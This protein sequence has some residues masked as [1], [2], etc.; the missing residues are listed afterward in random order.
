LPLAKR[1]SPQL[2]VSCYNPE[3]FSD[4]IDRIFQEAAMPFSGVTL[5]I[6]VLI[7]LFTTAEFALSQAKQIRDTA[8]KMRADDEVQILYTGSL[9]GYF[10]M[11]DWQHPVKGQKCPIDAI[12][13][14]A[15]EDFDTVVKGL[16][17]DPQKKLSGPILLSSG[18]SFS[19][20]IEAREFCTAP[21]NQPSGQKRVGKDSF[22]WN[23]ESQQWVAFEDYRKQ[24]QSFRDRVEAGM[25]TIPPDNVSSFLTAQ[26]YAAVVPGRHDFYFGPERLRLLARRLASDPIPDNVTMAHLP[27]Y[28]TQML[29]ANLVIE[30][31]WKS[32]HT[33]LS[34]KEDPP[35][36]IPRLPKAEELELPKT[37][38]FE[39]IDVPAGGN[40]YPWYVGSKLRLSVNKASPSKDSANAEE[41][42]EAQD[43]DE[44]KLK[45][46]S[47]DLR[48]AVEKIRALAVNLCEA[49]PGFDQKTRTQE[50]SNCRKIELKCKKAANKEEVTLAVQLPW[51][52]EAHTYTLK[53]GIQYRLCFTAKKAIVTDRDGGHTFCQRLSVYRP[54]FQFPW[55][56][57]SEVCVGSRSCPYTDPDPYLELERE[58][59]PG[60]FTDV[61][62][63]G[64]VN[65]NLVK[66]IGLLNYGWINREKNEKDTGFKTV[67]AAKDPAEA[68]KELMAHYERRW[69]E[70]DK[71]PKNA[72]TVKIR[73]LMAEMSPQEAE[74]LATRVRNFQVVLTEADEA[75]SKPFEND[76]KL[77]KVEADDGG[78]ARMPAVVLVPSP[79]FRPGAAK[80]ITDV[81]FLGL[82]PLD[83]EPEPQEW[84]LTSFHK[85]KNSCLYKSDAA[86]DEAATADATNEEKPFWSWL[87]RATGDHCVSGELSS[88][89]LKKLETKTL[90]E[91]RK[92]AKADVV[93]LQKRDFFSRLPKDFCKLRGEQRSTQEI[94]DRIIWKGD[95]LSRIFVPGSAIKKALEQSKAFDNEDSSALS[96]SDE[97]AL[98]LV[99]LG[100]VEDSEGSGYLI[101]GMPL[102]PNKLYAVATT[103]YI[104]AGDTGYPDLASGQLEQPIV[105]TDFGSNLTSISSVVCRSITKASDCEKDFPARDYFDV[106]RVEPNDPR[107]G[108]T[109]GKQLEIWSIFHRPSKVPGSSEAQAAV[110]GDEENVQQRSL[111]D[112]ALNKLSLGFTR[113][114]HTGSDFDVTS[115]FSGITSPGVN[116]LSNTILTS[117]FQATLAESR[118]RYQ[119]YLSPAYTYN[120]Q[121]KGQPDDFTQLNQIADLGSLDAGYVGLIGERSST[122]RGPE[123]LAFAMTEHFETPLTA[124]FN[125]FTLKTTHTG[126]HGELINDQL[127]FHLDR[128][129]TLLSRFGLRKKKRVSSIEFGPEWGHEFNA[130]TGINFTTSGTVV[131]CSAANPKQTIG[132]CFKANVAV[133]RPTT[134]VA[135]T[136]N[137]QDHTGAYWKVNL[138]VPFHPRVSY[139]LTD[140][141]DWFFVRY[142]TETSTT[143]LLR[144]Y[145]Q[146]QLKFTIFPS[147]SIGPEL[148]VLLYRNKAVGSLNGHFLFQDQLIMKA[149]WSFDLFNS[150]DKSKQIKY[151]PPGSSK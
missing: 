103:D 29:A 4:N 142:A 94:L 13:S 40:A 144:D 107:K 116:S 104:S 151:A 14:N 118:R 58:T 5:K 138:T 50:I 113:L 130:L 84:L 73:V 149:Q 117:D 46:L 70:A 55:G 150:T 9:M 76:T 143:T 38:K 32:D 122:K 31:T 95:F 129:Y 106:L 2:H 39:E 92:E 132:Q 54:F 19:P 87:G 100:V 16:A 71:K 93:L 12:K 67:V 41:A 91:L 128:S 52:D 68:L 140:S 22:L 145:S 102:D 119:L 88:D 57:S 66:N 97:R 62:I 79:F 80:G 99:T 77:V 148:D 75:R 44:C 20:E 23:D 146:H 35:R 139:V 61:A 133:M 47:D 135:S 126:E 105:G 43:S 124:A 123:Y 120:V 114:S 28:G 81:G 147:F 82:Q 65:P 27:G 74:V 37:V 69:E 78:K 24:S 134:V 56:N 63:F 3:I 26:G 34:D 85:S 108:K 7:S 51:Q 83:Q 109:P 33:A 110:G 45:E 96:L 72:K 10:R 1:I 127:R 112:F 30:T 36:F 90:V 49:P 25:G 111:T 136:R 21:P 42:V 89:E 115:N 6:V 141:G 125:A 137:G 59:A 60:N 98:G 11:P 53:P 17:G 8:S 131:P 48:T 15:V 18:N 101:N 86:C 64:V 121:Y